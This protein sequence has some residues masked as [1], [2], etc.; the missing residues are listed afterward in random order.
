[1][2]NKAGGIE[3]EKGNFEEAARGISMEFPAHLL[4]VSLLSCSEPAEA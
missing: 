3:F 2:P 1:M 4:A